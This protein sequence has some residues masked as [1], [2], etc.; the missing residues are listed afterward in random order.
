MQSRNRGGALIEVVVAAAVLSVVS[1]S[2]LGA[3]S[4]LSRAHQRDTL[5]IK[6]SLL[7]EEGVEALRFVK[8]AGWSGLS[9]A[10]GQTRYLSLGSSS[11]SLS[12]TPEVID[13]AFYRTVTVSAVRRDASDDIVASG[14]TVDA[15]ALL[16]KSTVSWNWRG[17]T[18]TVS[19]TSYVTNI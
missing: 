11:W 6:G 4:M 18:S 13:G 17:A 15:N 9:A 10:V 8:A 7:A 12:T 5:A 19:Y 3:F 1:L 16:L 2:F 14:G